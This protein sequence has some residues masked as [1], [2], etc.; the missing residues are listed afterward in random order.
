MQL[1]QNVCIYRSA[2]NDVAALV[3][4][5]EA[6]LCQIAAVFLQRRND[7]G[8][9]NAEGNIPVRTEDYVLHVLG[10]D[11][12]LMAYRL[13]DYDI[14]AHGNAVI[15]RKYAQDELGECRPRRAA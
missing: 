12:G 10:K 13:T 5:F 1:R 6:F 14:H 2:G 4:D 3:G 7:L 11:R 9:R 8:A 15:G